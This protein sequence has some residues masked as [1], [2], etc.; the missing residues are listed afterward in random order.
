[1]IL[2]LCQPIIQELSDAYNNQSAGLYTEPTGGQWV[3]FV[4]IAIGRDGKPGLSAH[5]LLLKVLV[6]K[7][8]CGQD[9]C[10]QLAAMARLSPVNIF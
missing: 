1:M 8:N 2:P 3:V 7:I 6:I 9:L 10:A 5:S 4:S